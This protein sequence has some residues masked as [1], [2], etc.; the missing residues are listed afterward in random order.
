MTNT[1][2]WFLEINTNPFFSEF[3]KLTNNNLAKTIH[4]ELNK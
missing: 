3:N 4:E 1:Q 2:D